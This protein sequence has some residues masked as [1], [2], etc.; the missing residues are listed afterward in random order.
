MNL[1]EYLNALH[2]MKNLIQTNARSFESIKMPTMDE[3]NIQALEVE[4]YTSILAKGG[5]G[6]LPSLE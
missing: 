6:W 3:K 1:T 4:E 2:V 5:K